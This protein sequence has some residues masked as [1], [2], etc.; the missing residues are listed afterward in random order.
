MR[1][2]GVDPGTGSFDLALVEGE[3]VVWERSIPTSIIA[4]DPSS[5]IRAIEESGAD[6]VAAP[7]GYGVPI[8]WADEVRDPVRFA[9]EVLL[10]SEPQQ[11]DRVA[12]EVGVG[13][14]SALAKVVDTLVRSGVR[15]VFAPSV[16][17]LRSIPPLR[18]L[19]KVDMGTA[20]KL[21]ATIVGIWGLASKV[22]GADDVNGVFMELGFG[23]NAAMSV[24]GGR[25]VDGIG[26]TYATMGPLTAGA[27][28][29]EVVTGV[30]EWFRFDVYK[31][32]LV[33]LCGTPDLALAERAYL[34]GEEPCASAFSAWLEGI[35]KD[36]ARASVPLGRRAGLVVLSGR[37]SGLA[38]VRRALAEAGYDVLEAPRLPGSAI[39]KQAAHG[40]AAMA[41]AAAGDEGA[42]LAEV[43]GRVGVRDACGT[44]VDHLVHPSAKAFRERVRRAYLE[45][46]TRPR[47]C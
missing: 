36:V 41:L 35:V 14:Y 23:Y 4:S 29:L 20:D 44:V 3:R 32:G 21:A 12:G 30:G 2:L 27:V 9:Y 37:Y 38:S 6:V 1:A 42:L 19:N 33:E 45:T 40:Y 5:L 46:V 13:V 17:L 15:A 8:T 22:G 10:L 26:G 7:S 24:L 43:A 18:K 34:S 31:G 25:L 39:T 28:D 11:L 16:I 47:L